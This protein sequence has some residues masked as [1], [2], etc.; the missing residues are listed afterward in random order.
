LSS[1]SSRLLG[2]NFFLPSDKGNETLYL[3]RDVLTGRLLVAENVASSETEM[4]KQVLSPVVNLGMPV[5]GVISDAQHSE[6]LAVAQL[7]PEVPHQTCQ[8]H[9]LREASQ[10]IYDVDRS[11]RTAMRK[12][13]GNRLKKTRNQMGQ[14]LRKEQEQAALAKPGEQEQLQVLADY[15][16]GINTALN[17]EG[18]QPFEY[19]GIAAFDAL[20]E[21]EQSLRQLEKKG[22]PEVDFIQIFQA[23][24]DHQAAKASVSTRRSKR[25]RGI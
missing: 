9:Y 11:M 3:V 18:T 20:E 13:I 5:L 7:W 25:A 12:T 23:M 6:R 2:R 8:F 24:D 10:P 15:A 17:L 16:L 21:I 14:Q 19:P 22:T 4:M 1:Q